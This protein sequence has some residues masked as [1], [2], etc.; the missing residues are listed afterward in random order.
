MPKGNYR[1]FDGGTE[2]D[3]EQMRNVA[4]ANAA[5]RAMKTGRNHSVNH[6][7]GKAVSVH[8]P[9]GSESSEPDRRGRPKKGSK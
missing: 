2:V 1:I 3:H 5:E 7:N 4:K 6:V 9:D 8:F